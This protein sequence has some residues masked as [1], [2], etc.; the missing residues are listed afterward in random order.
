M[1]IGI[2]GTGAVGQ[3]IARD[4]ARAGF[5]LTLGSSRGPASLEALT[6]EL[7]PHVRAGTVREAA[8]ADVVFLAAPWTQ[9][10][11]ALTDLQPWDGRIVIDAGRTSSEG[12]A[13]LV[14]GARLV[15]AFN[16]LPA[17]LRLADP[18]KGEGRRVL[19]LSGEDGEARET[20]ARIVEAMGFAPIDLGTLVEGGERQ[21]LPEEPSPALELVRFGKAR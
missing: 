14:P 13:A 8:A 2:I 20:V 16:T 4:V 5:A 10:K 9:L 11:S 1:K 3:A 12:V 19:F 18:M 7:G 21:Q 15:R 17:P 6:K